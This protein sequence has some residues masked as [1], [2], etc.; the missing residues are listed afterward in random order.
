[1]NNNNQPFR[2]IINSGSCSDTSNVAVLTVNNNVG[3]NENSQNNLFTVF[4]N[5]AK[6]IINVK[7]DSKLIGS[8]YSIFDNK[9][10]VV[11]TGKISSE[12]TT[13]EL[14][15]LTSGIYMFSVGENMKQSFKVI[16]E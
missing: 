14:G 8:D 1:M 3:I 16:K 12:N 5:P 6:S 13:I 10:G 9:G 11:Q 15:Q 4:S 7:T 2:C